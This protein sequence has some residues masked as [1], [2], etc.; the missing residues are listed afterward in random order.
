MNSINVWTFLTFVDV[1][2][3]LIIYKCSELGLISFLLIIRSSIS[4]SNFS[5]LHLLYFVCN[6]IS[7]NFFSIRRTLFRYFVISLSIMNMSFM[8]MILSWFSS[9][10]NTYVTYFWKV[11]RTLT[12]LNDIIRYSNVSYRVLNTVFYLFSSLILIWL[13]TFFRSIL[14]N[15][16][17]S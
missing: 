5:N 14:L 16:I 7:Y 4:I 2:Y 6:L 12:N 11:S 13:N 15:I 1:F 3:S 9:F 8:Y 17:F 10:F